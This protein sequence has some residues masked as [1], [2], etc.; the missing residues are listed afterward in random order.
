M[1][2]SESKH[3]D[4]DASCTYPIFNEGQIAFCDRPTT[5]A[6]RYDE[7]YGWSSRCEVHAASS[8]YIRP[9]T[10][11]LL[12]GELEFNRIM[13]SKNVSEV[14]RYAT[15]RGITGWASETALSHAA[16]LKRLRCQSKE[17]L[18]YHQNKNLAIYEDGKKR[19]SLLCSVCASPDLPRYAWSPYD[20]G[21]QF[22][23]TKSAFEKL[24]GECDSN[25]RKM[26]AALGLSTPRL[27]SLFLD[28]FK[29][30]FRGWLRDYR[31]RCSVPRIPKSTR[32]T[33]SL[34]AIQSKLG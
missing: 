18:S 4:I 27:E 19:L 15:D 25:P 16:T 24:A 28:V 32:L 23:W 17:C 2:L 3:L 34:Y 33:I 9:L 14:L 12:E 21:P 26:A 5:H 29:C 7:N 30:R 1:R 13:R 6:K 31:K 8:P 22:Y 20:R 11:I 10:D